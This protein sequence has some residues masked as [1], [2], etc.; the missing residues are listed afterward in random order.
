MEL[1]NRVVQVRRTLRSEEE[2]LPSFSPEDIILPFGD[3]AK[4]VGLVLNQNNP[5]EGFVVFPNSESVTNILKVADTS[6]CVGIHMNLT[7][8]RPR[9]E[10]IPIIA[11][12]LGDNALEE[13]EE[14]EFIPIEE[15][16]AKGSAHFST[17]KK[18]EEPVAPQLAEQIK[19]LQT[20]ELNQILSAISQ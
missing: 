16:V 1:S 18:G 9:V 11:R 8:D 20:K 17:L 13:G 12:L 2:V 4:P 5:S 6:K 14:Y 19:S 15:F 7:I 10:I 3:L